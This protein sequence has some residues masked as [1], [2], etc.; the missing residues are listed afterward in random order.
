MNPLNIAAGFIFGALVARSILAAAE[1]IATYRRN[2][3]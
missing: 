2:T 3:P 1:F